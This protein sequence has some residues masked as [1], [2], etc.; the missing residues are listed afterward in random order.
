MTS[1]HDREFDVEELVD[2]LR[3]ALAANPNE[4]RTSVISREWD[5]L[6]ADGWPLNVLAEAV[7]EVLPAE[8]LSPAEEELSALYAGLAGQLAAQGH[9]WL[10][11]MRATF[12]AA[13]GWGRVHGMSHGEIAV[14][15]ESL[16]AQ[17]NAMAATDALIDQAIREAQEEE[18]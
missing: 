11:L 12:A 4:T 10:S 8:P 2:R 17:A 18:D 3:G 9:G 15:L 13:I 7:R 6:I 1:N 5:V 16:A 14:E